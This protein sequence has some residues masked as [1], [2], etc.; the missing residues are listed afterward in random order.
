MGGGGGGGFFAMKNGP[1]GQFTM[2]VH[3]SS[4][5]GSTNKN[6]YMMAAALEIVQQELWTI[7]VFR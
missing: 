2:E 1:Q 5:T 6:Q 7:F 3:F 4:H